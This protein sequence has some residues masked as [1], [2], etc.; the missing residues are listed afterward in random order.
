M[1][2]WGLIGAST[3]ARE[4]VIGA[5]RAKGGEVV[6]VLS[7]NAERGRAYAAQNGIVRAATA[8]DEILSDPGID[9]VYISTTNELHRDQAIAAA[10]AG[11]H[12]L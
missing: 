2:R 4:W 6:S 3:I 10:R 9:A 8:L 7:S 11:K 5:I 12:V 1:V